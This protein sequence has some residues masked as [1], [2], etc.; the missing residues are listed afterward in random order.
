MSKTMKS[1]KSA[2]KQIL[3][4]TLLLSIGH[5]SVTHAA[6]SQELGLHEIS[7]SFDNS[8]FGIGQ[9][10]E[11]GGEDYSDESG[12]TFIELSQ[13]DSNSYSCYSAG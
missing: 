10:A 11:V 7:E 1:L 4:I 12:Q 8:H 5:A 6:T 2:I 13:K 9:T 3:A